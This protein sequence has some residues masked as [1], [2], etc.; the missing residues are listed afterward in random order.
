[1]DQK[2]LQSL[3]TSLSTLYL[4]IKVNKV[5]SA[6]ILKWKGISGWIL[7]IVI[8]ARHPDIKCLPSCNMTN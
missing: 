8:S 5:H 2:N 1:M 6:V 3:I 4:Y 7:G